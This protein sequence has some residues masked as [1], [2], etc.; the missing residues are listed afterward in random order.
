MARGSKWCEI[1]PAPHYQYACW[2]LIGFGLDDKLLGVSCES[3]STLSGS[4]RLLLLYVPG[5][6]VF[7]FAVGCHNR[8]LG[9]VN[10]VLFSRSRLLLLQFFSVDLDCAADFWL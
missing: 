6:A 7:F 2:T 1:I 5:T 4:H 8:F 9:A 3:C 10:P